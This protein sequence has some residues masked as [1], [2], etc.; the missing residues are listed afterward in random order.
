MCGVAGAFGYVDSKLIQAVEQVSAA[1]LHRGP[2]GHGLWFSSEGEEQAVFAHR[3]LAIIDLTEGGHQPMVH[4]ETG[5]TLCFNGEIYNYR[6][7]REE[8][9]QLGHH[10]CSESDGEVLLVAYCE[11]GEAC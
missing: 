3:R 6:I 10:F 8:L 4:R 11:W 5:N 7:L 1:Q 9:Q 2:D